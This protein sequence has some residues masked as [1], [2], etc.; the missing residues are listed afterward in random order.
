MLNILVHN[1]HTVDQDRIPGSFLS[2]LRL[3]D[4]S[5]TPQLHSPKQLVVLLVCI[6][7]DVDGSFIL[8]H[9]FQ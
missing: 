5:L 9:K 4:D 3:M 2:N 7:S 6:G 8:L 1:V